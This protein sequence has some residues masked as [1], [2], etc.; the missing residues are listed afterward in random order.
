MC[1]DVE[2]PSIAEKQKA[3]LRAELADFS[4]KAK[5]A[6]AEEKNAETAA[7]A[8]EKNAAATEEK[9]AK[10]TAAPDEKAED[11]THRGE[12]KK[13]ASA[14]E[15]KAAIKGPTAAAAAAA[16]ADGGHAKASVLPAEQQG[17]A[18]ASGGADQEEGVAAARVKLFERVQT[19]KALTEA[20]KLDLSFLWRLRKRSACSAP[21]GEGCGRIQA[22]AFM[23][24]MQ[25]YKRDSESNIGNG[26]HG[27]YYLQTASQDFDDLTKERAVAAEG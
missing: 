10:T 25:T 14:E 16:A 15:K 11:N 22:D 12:A 27:S 8:E 2:G 20:T 5:V 9:N 1:V 13:A 17:G 24:K 6:A 23:S 4:E 7:A 18:A 21:A 19:F 3:S 26:E